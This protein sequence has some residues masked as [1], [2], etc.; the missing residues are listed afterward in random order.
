MNT[1]PN[2]EIGVVFGIILT[3]HMHFNFLHGRHAACQL[4]DATGAMQALHQESCRH[5]QTDIHTVTHTAVA[6]HTSLPRHVCDTPHTSTQETDEAYH[7]IIKHQEV[8]DQPANIQL[9]HDCGRRCALGLRNLSHDQNCW[10]NHHMSLFGED[11]HPLYKLHS[12]NMLC[13]YAR[14]AV[15]QVHDG[16]P[17][18]VIAPDCHQDNQT[19]ACAML[20]AFFAQLDLNLLRL[21]ATSICILC[22][23]GCSV[24]SF[25]QLLEVQWA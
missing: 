1:L 20:D 2:I 24:S 9:V 22:A 13:A 3:P 21:H 4:L 11:T 8:L 12:N 23:K 7:I 25:A 5:K 14:Y 6:L 10:L 18:H 17:V 16:K 15:S 19:T